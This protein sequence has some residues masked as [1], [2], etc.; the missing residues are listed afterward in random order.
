LLIINLYK[1]KLKSNISSRTIKSVP[2]AADQRDI[3]LSLS[4][5][6][7]RVK[8][9]D[10]LIGVISE[11]LKIPLGFEHISVC[12]LDKTG[13]SFSIFLFDPE[14]RSREH[15]GYSLLK[16]RQFPL[17]DGITEQILL[18]SGPKAFDLDKLEGR[19]P[20][21]LSMN[22]PYGIKQVVAQR[23]NGESGAA[24][25]LL[26][27]YQ[28]PLHMRSSTATFIS[29]VGD[30]V[31]IAVS[32]IIAH[33]EVKALLETKTKLLQFGIDLRTQTDWKSLSATISHQFENLFATADFAVTLI[34]EEGNSHKLILHNQS[35]ISELSQDINYPLDK[36]MFPHLLKQAGPTLFKRADLLPAEKKSL[37]GLLLS[38]NPF[39]QAVGT[40]MSLGNETV[41]FILFM[42]AGIEN[43][44]TERQL[45]ESLST[46]IAIVA[47]HMRAQGKVNEQLAEIAGYKKQLD[48]DKSH[49][50]AEIRT[51]NHNGE[52]IGNG[53]KITKVLDLVSSVAATDTTTLIMGETGTGKELLAKAIHNNSNRKDR[54]LV[55]VNCAALP[56]SLIESE[57]FGHEK[58]SFTGAWEQRLG[59][60][61]LASGGTLFLDE[62]AEIPLEVQ[63]KLLRV[64]QE[65]EIERIGGTGPIAVDVRI[66]AATNRN[67]EKEMA[68][69][70]FRKDLFYRL[71]IFPISIP[72][73]RERPEDLIPLAMH[74]TA[75]YSKKFSKKISGISEETMEKIKKYPWPGNVRELEHWIERSILL[76]DGTVISQELYAPSR[77]NGMVGL[78]SQILR[79]IDENEIS[80][81]T[82][83]MEYCGKRISGRGG[84]AEILGV[85]PSTLNSK[86]K[87][88]GIKK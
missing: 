53:S 1:E 46:Q 19:L 74:F 70:R 80:H 12:L 73:L 50:I 68:L 67:L 48:R 34:N 88:L 26:M 36:D 65:K 84:A 37:S 8:S 47:L 38:V 17:K 62:I 60:F 75:R 18:E 45:L 59:K 64:L 61:E 4:T 14:S 63:V 42:G 72:P 13:K 83:V 15:P 24:G 79:T 35:G 3:L 9:Q 33:R 66:I 21:Y 5:D 54:L 23:I 44:S 43:F 76:T 56:V 22:K 6:I 57:L 51:L 78:E 30:L 39:E 40:V 10:Q 41:G 52:I 86:I 27:F 69:G 49:L 71:N 11:R 20:P 82:R 85:P 32:N 7:A 58:G 25:F 55:K 29:G 87:R 16:G 81:I 77:E 31:S 28:Q 2:S